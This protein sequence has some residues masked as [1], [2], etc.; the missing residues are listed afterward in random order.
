MTTVAEL[1]DA[2]RG[3]DPASRALFL[4]EYADSDEADEIRDV[5]IPRDAWTCDSG[6]YDGQKYS[7]RYPG[8]LLRGI[9]DKVM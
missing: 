1:I 6:R 2:L 3:A 9:L 8:P 5:V 4:G 7:V